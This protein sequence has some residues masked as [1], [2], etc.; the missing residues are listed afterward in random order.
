MDEVER[1]IFNSKMASLPMFPVLVNGNYIHL[2]SQ[3]ENLVLF[4]DLFH[5]HI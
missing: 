5:M 2:P 1:G 4:H 3:V